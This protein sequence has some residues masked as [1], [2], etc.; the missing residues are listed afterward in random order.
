ML[1]LCC[2]ISG[3]FPAFT[4]GII[5]SYIIIYIA[6]TQSTILDHML[7]RNSTEPNITIDSFTLHS[8]KIFGFIT[9]YVI[10]LPF[11]IVPTDTIKDC[12]PHSN[13]NFLESVWNFS[14]LMKCKMFAITSV[15]FH[16]DTSPRIL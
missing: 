5:D 8:R 3:T 13:L 2:V 12:G 1:G 9:H 10:S 6:I 14:V 7:G 15:T 16:N 4:T 11:Q